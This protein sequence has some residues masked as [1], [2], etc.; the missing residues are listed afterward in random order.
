[1]NLAKNLKRIREEK[2]F[3]TAKKFTTSKLFN[4]ISYE[5][6]TTYESGA[7]TPPVESLIIIADA[8]SVSIDDLLGRK[9]NKKSPIDDA[10]DVFKRLHIK[11]EK[12]PETSENFIFVN[13]KVIARLPNEEI[14]DVV[15]H[16]RHFYLFN[17]EGIIK[18]DVLYSY[19]LRSVIR[20][21]ET[22]QRVYKR[23]GGKV[24]HRKVDFPYKTT[25]RKAKALSKM[26]NNVLERSNGGDE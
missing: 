20:Y 9:L 23:V 15:K 25:E 4:K 21:G 2:G 7:R 24:E 19:I 5:T 11:T 22:G 8:L 13:G 14:I 1:M 16:A 6:Y 10:L 12:D 26:I 18:H 17:I 3:K